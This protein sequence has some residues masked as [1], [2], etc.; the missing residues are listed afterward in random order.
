MKWF[1]K[2][3]ICGDIGFREYNICSDSCYDVHLDNAID[4]A[5]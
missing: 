5:W 3:P 2:C 1:R 4:S